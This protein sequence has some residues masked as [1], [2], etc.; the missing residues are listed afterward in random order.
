M[1]IHFSFI[2]TVGEKNGKWN[3]NAYFRLS[4]IH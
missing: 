1:N 2:S 3:I 4:K